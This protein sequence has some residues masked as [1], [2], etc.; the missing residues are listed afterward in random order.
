MNFALQKESRLHL[1]KRVYNI[2]YYNAIYKGIYVMNIL[3]ML[4]DSQ[5]TEQS[6]KNMW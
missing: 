3:Y 2:W 4:A 1:W 5:P 6:A